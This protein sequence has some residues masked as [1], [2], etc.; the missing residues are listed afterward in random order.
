MDVKIEIDILGS[1]IHDID[2]GTMAWERVRAMVSGAS[3]AQCIG[4]F[5]T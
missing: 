3:Q 4:V 1:L 2:D 5:S